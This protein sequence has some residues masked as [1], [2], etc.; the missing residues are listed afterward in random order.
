MTVGKR[1]WGAALVLGVL[2]VVAFGVIAPPERCPSVSAADL[3][4]S[5]QSAVDSRSIF[6][7]RSG[8]LRVLPSSPTRLSSL[9]TWP[10]FSSSPAVDWFARNQRTNGRGL[11]EYHRGDD[12]TSPE[13]N[14]VRHTGAVMG[15]YQAAA[16]GLPG[17]L[18]SADRG[19]AWALDRLTERDGWAA[20][21]VGGDTATGATHD[22]L[23]K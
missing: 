7:L 1:I 10:A 5:T 19:A 13:Y 16:A 17:A 14:D 6:G 23:R 11:Y 18:G 20:V 15:L 22:L 12:S 9:D 3:E 4:R 2:L 21:T 8:S